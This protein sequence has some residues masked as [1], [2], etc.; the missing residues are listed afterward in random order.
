MNKIDLDTINL[1]IN[2]FI[3]QYPDPDVILVRAL[4]IVGKAAIIFYLVKAEWKILSSDIY[5]TISQ[6]GLE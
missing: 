6:A 1:I 2:C 4:L 5:G 3:N